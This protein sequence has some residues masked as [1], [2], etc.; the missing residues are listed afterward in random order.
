MIMVLMTISFTMSLAFACA[1]ANAENPTSS[2]SGKKFCI[3]TKFCSD[4]NIQVQAQLS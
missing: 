2:K 4:N 1:I 3:N